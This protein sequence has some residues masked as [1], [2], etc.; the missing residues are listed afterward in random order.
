MPE[1]PEVR[2]EAD[3]IQDTLGDTPI[4]EV[5]FKFDHLKYAQEILRGSRLL[6]VQTVGKGFLLHFDC[7][8]SIY[9]HNQLYGRWMFA[10]KI[11]ESAR[12]LRL[13][14]KSKDRYALLYSASEIQFL[15]S[16][17]VPD[18]AFV[19]NNSG[20]DILNSRPTI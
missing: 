12:D 3:Q 11:P 18:I 7:G 5:Y 2:R 1:G 16:E 10:P 15:P 6:F 20:L 4:S 19:K 8:F 14:L 17:N 9:G 13:M